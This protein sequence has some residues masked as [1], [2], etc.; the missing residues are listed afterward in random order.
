MITI[1]GNNIKSAF[2]GGMPV[3]AIY[4]FGVK[5]WPTEPKIEYVWQ[6]L[7]TTSTIYGSYVWKSASGNVFYSQGLTQ[8]YY[9]NGSWYT[10]SWGTNTP[11]TGYNVWTDNDG[12]TYYTS[13]SSSSNISYRLESGTW[14]NY[15][16]FSDGNT[17]EG[18]YV[19]KDNDGNIYCSNGSAQYRWEN[20]SGRY[21][22]TPYTWTGFKPTY[23]NLIWKDSE[24]N[25][26]YSEGSTQYQLVSGTW[27]VKSWNRNIERGDNV[28]QGYDGHI[29][30][31]SVDNYSYIQ[32]ELVDGS[33]VVKSWG[34]YKPNTG[35]HI[36]EDNTGRIIYSAG[37]GY[38]SELVKVI[39]S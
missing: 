1:F 30:Y 17:Q 32:Y 25:V 6:K 15:F 22:F 31:S 7:S 39:E 37:G 19:W 12:N 13:K 35:M 10:K 24:G 38:Q 34:D 5:V 27:V 11:A 29:Y 16:T 3:K 36:W 26:Y 8:Y 21:V 23:G 28:W 4:S 2:T 18:R 20:L 33:W 9:S 14:V